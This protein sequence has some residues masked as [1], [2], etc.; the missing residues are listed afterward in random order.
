[1]HGGREESSN[2][3]GRSAN[4]RGLNDSPLKLWVADTIERVGDGI[5]RSI[6]TFIARRSRIA[7]GVTMPGKSSRHSAR[8]LEALIEG[9]PGM[10]F[11]FSD[12]GSEFEGLFDDLLQERRI[13]H[14]WTYPRSPKM[15]AH[16][17]RFNRTIQ[18]QFVDFHEDLLFTDIDGFNREIGRWLIEY[19]TVL[20][21]H[22]LNLKSPARWLIEKYPQ[23]HK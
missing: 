17:E 9:N 1:M 10:G 7:F 22:S 13:Q 5:R 12:N 14:Y 6:I 8:A 21:H 19:N 18:E 2:V 11:L 20:P 23:C 4:L 15:N 3:F 16:S